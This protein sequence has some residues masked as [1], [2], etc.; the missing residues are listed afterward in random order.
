MPT[1]QRSRP[2]LFVTTAGF[3]VIVGVLVTIALV[4]VD[5]P[6]FGWLVG[7]PFLETVTIAIVTGAAAMG[8]GA[9]KSGA[10]SGWRRP[11]L[12]A[13][14]VVAAASPAFGP[15]LFLLPWAALALSS[16]AAIFALHRLWRDGSS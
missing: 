14:A 7:G 16:P 9:W 4:I 8:I 3:L 6:R 12:L 15:Y 1:G 13:W 5:K 11:M 2:W 10:R